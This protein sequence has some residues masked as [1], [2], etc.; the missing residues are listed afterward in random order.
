MK[1]PD[2]L[3]TA[4]I[5]L[6]TAVA[7]PAADTDDP[8]PLVR[9][10]WLVQRKGDA[11][12]LDPRDDLRIK[13]SIFK[14]L[15]KDGILTPEGVAGLMD[16]STFDEL[17][18]PD[19][20][21][22]QAEIRK[23]LEAEVPESRRRLLPAVA[24]HA[25]ALST[26]FDRI[27]EAHRE[28]GDTLSTWIAKE[29]RPGKASHVTVICTGNSRRSILGSTM[30]NV[31]AAYAGMPEVCFHSGGTAPTAFNPRTI[32]ALREIGIEVEPT[33]DEAPRGEPE[34]ANPRYRLRWGLPGRPTSRRSRRRNSRRS[35][36]T[37][38]IPL[39]TSPP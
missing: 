3:A 36:T 2:L 26:S 37:R 27:D 7:S 20:R 12:A 11:A 10:L 14:A 38:P 29:Y 13:G 34:T 15:G 22:D 6:A 25:D 19:R 18:G 24:A 9:S 35:T 17:A 8:G 31:A 28:A 23:V 32:A 4:A 5:V 21:L 16:P 30:G 33:G 1:R 39:A